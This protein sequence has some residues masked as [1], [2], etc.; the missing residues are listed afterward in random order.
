MK[1]AEQ[2]VGEPVAQLFSF[3]G[4]DVAHHLRDILLGKV[5]ESSEH[6]RPTFQ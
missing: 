1:K 5:I 6:L 2:L 3:I 4:V